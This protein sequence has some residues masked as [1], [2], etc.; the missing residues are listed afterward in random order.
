MYWYL[1]NRYDN[2]LTDEILIDMDHPRERTRK[3]VM[4]LD[5]FF[6]FRMHSARRENKL[7]VDSYHIV[8]SV[9]GGIHIY[10]CLYD[11]IPILQALIWKSWLGDDLYR[12]RCDLMRFAIGH[13]YPSLLVE[14]APTYREANAVCQCSEKHSHENITCETYKQFRGPS[15]WTLF[16]APAEALMN[17][18]PFI[19]KVNTND[20]IND[21]N[22]INHVNKV[23]D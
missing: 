14:T 15:P 7:P 21:D 3:G 5:A 16:G 23:N 8:T 4:Y 11:K 17:E 10:V 13:K 1:M 19:R 22:E 6:T 20:E 9:S 12:A 18:G 2:E